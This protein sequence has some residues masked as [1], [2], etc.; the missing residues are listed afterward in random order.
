MKSNE[1]LGGSD[2]EAFRFQARYYVSMSGP[3]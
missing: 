3:T 2:R 1:K